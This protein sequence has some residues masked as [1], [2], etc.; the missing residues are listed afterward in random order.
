MLFLLGADLPSVLIVPF[1]ALLGLFLFPRVMLIVA[2]HLKPCLRRASGRT[3][4][5]RRSAWIIAHRT[6]KP[7]DSGV[8]PFCTGRL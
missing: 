7:L 1:T 4:G 3:M 5:M 8:G 2:L 6:M